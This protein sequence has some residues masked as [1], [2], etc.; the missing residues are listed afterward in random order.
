MKLTGRINVYQADYAGCGREERHCKGMEAGSSFIAQSSA[1]GFLARSPKGNE[2]K[3]KK[4][5]D[6]K[7]LKCQ[8]INFNLY[9]EG[10]EK[11]LKI[12]PK[13]NDDIGV[14]C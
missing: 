3:K 11:T 4:K 1:S 10:N 2:G 8:T 9:T 5:S 12:F 14:L 13:R 6:S 7:E